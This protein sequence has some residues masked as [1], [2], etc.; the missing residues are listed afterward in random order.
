MKVFV[1]N[2]HIAVN[3]C[4]VDDLRS[5]G[6]EVLMP[7]TDF[8]NSNFFAPN[9]EHFSKSRVVPVDKEVF[10]QMPPMAIIINCD[11]LYK[12]LMTLYEERDKQDTLIFMPV[13][14]ES[15]SVFD[16]NGSD[17]I[18]AHDL[19]YY[20]KTTAKYKILYFS[21]PLMFRA[22]REERAASRLFAMFKD[23]YNSYESCNFIKSY[24]NNYQDERFY[25]ERFE[26]SRFENRMRCKIPQF[27]YNCPDGWLAQDKVQDEMVDSLFTL[28]F[29][30]PETWAQTVLQSMLLGVPCIFL[31]RF[32]QYATIRDY[33]I[34]VDNSIIG[35]TVEQCVDRIKSLPSEQYLTLCHEA[36]SQAQLYCE[37][38]NRRSKLK[39]LFDKVQIKLEPD[40]ERSLETQK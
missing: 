30:R 16:I 20:R 34:T 37:D 19:N 32:L 29:K 9:D 7:K 4:L 38:S 39:W 26:F 8:Y 35:Q 15:I 17:F 27:G 6:L 23:A 13:Q 24:V 12:P 2:Y 11:Q 10:M 31:E 5:I 33:L 36:K 14:S 1:T 18:I 40:N 28:S 25:D 3:H 22:P 21:K